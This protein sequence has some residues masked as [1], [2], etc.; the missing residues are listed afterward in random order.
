MRLLLKLGTGYQP[1]QSTSYLI[2]YLPAP[3]TLYKCCQSLALTDA[4]LCREWE[5]RY[6]SFNVHWNRAANEQIASMRDG[7]GSE[8]FI[9]FSPFGVVGKALNPKTAL[10]DSTVALQQ[11]PDVFQS[12][13]TE[14][15]FDLD[16]I[17]IVFWYEYAVSQW[18]AHPKILDIEP[19]Y[20]LLQGFEYYY[21]WATDYYKMDINYL[22]MKTV[23]ETQTLNALQ[24]KD[25]N[26]VIK[27]ADL[28]PDWLEILGTPLIS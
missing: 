12:F 9:L 26:P 5:Y 24:L 28:N 7:L 10:Q 8:Y 11:V 19:L 22:T 6:F 16:Y 20:F 23:F 17:S 4:I 27:L 25:L 18:Y 14:P 15:A 13:K 2:M 1:L 21:K 3:N